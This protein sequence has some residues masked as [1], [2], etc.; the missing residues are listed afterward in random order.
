MPYFKALLFILAFAFMSG[1]SYFQPL[2][3]K[4]A[5]AIKV[6]CKEPLAARELLISTI[7]RELTPNEIKVYCAGDPASMKVVP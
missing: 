4:V 3:E 5:E 1:C 7:N 2:T 6:Y